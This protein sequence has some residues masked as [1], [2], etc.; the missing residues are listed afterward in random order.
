MNDVVNALFH[1]VQPLRM[2]WVWLILLIPIAVA[3]WFLTVQIIFGIP[4][5]NN[6]APDVVTL[7][8]WV[9]A[10]VGLPL[11]AYSA[12]L[13]TDVRMDGIFLRYFPFYSRIITFSDVIS[14]EIR[15]YRPLVEYG[16]WCIRFGGQ[17]KRAYTMSGN[18]GVELELSDGTRF[19]IGSQRPEELASAIDA[20]I[21]SF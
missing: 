4:V 9:F 21:A 16:G 7:L 10:G 1:E 12:K 20:A 13:I 3:R 8:I 17:R 2:W 14:H 11:F 5:G 6:P 15:E 19:L 18:K